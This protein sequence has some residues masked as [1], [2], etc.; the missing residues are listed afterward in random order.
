VLGIERSAALD[1]E[2]DRVLQMAD[3]GRAVAG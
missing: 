1:E 2:L 3:R